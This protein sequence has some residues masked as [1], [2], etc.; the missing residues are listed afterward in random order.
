[1]GRVTATKN[2][3]PLQLIYTEEFVIYKE[4]LAREKL[5]KTLQ[6]GKELR[7]I[8]DKLNL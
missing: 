2:R 6:G 3:R 8:L 4:A 7:K 5:S 1:M